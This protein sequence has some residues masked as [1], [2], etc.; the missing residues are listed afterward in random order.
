LPFSKCK[1]CDGTGEIIPI[2]L[3]LENHDA[4]P[5]CP[6]CGGTGLLQPFAKLKILRVWRQELGTMTPQECWVEG[7][8]DWHGFMSAFVNLNRQ[9]SEKWLGM[10]VGRF[11]RLAEMVVWA[12]KFE[13]VSIRGKKKI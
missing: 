11:S 4:N 10:A 2:S 7:F 9:A 1:H 6:V 5:Y 13:R 3:R 8:A 12:V